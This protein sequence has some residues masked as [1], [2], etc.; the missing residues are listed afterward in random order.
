M[1]DERR[2]PTLPEVEVQF[3]VAE[4]RPVD[5]DLLV[6][7]GANRDLC[8][9]DRIIRAQSLRYLQRIVQLLEELKGGNGTAGKSGTGAHNRCPG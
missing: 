5:R 8:D 6:Y 4:M 2:A 3:R 7:G 1:N 9:T